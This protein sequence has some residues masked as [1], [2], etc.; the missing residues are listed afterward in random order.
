MFKLT[1]NKTL[2]HSQLFLIIMGP[3]YINCQLDFVETVIAYERRIR[4]KKFEE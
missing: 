1:T 4:Y 3:A 2:A